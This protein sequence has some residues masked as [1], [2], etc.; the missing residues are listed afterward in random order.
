MI[1]FAGARVIEQTIRETAARG[2]PDAPNTCCDHGMVDAVVHRRDLK[3]MLG[4][5]LGLMMFR[6]PSAEVVAL[7]QPD[8]DIPDQDVAGQRTGHDAS[9]EAGHGAG[10]GGTGDQDPD[11]RAAAP[12]PAGTDIKKT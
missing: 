11:D 10:H 9:Q 8:L 5:L 6:E 12:L 2:L 3:A 1:G 7:P 4:R